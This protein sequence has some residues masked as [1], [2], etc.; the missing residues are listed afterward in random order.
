MCVSVSVNIGA[1]IRAGVTGSSKLPDVG[2]KLRSCVRAACAL[3]CQAFSPAL[4]VR[5]K[6]ALS[7]AG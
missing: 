5:L 7:R 6:K 3:N 1:L 4:H 2:V